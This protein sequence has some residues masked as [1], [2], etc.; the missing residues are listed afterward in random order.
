MF[1][2]VLMF[3]TIML[4]IEMFVNV[5]SYPSHRVYINPETGQLITVK[6]ALP[7]RYRMPVGESEPR[8]SGST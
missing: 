3:L 2:F 8:Q 5:V 1:P 7:A 6:R 4:Y